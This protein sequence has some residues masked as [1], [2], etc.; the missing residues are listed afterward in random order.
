VITLDPV[1]LPKV[2]E[3]FRLPKWQRVQ[4][5]GLH[6]TENGAS[7]ADAQREGKH[8]HG[9]EPGRSAQHS[10]SIAQVL[11]KIDHGWLPPSVTC[12]FDILVI[13]AIF[14]TFFAPGRFITEAKTP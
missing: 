11:K 1:A 5:D 7:G 9:G 4:D 8:G 14:L 10:Q 12:V 2:N 3:I 6:H 13:L